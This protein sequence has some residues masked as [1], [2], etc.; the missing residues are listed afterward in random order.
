LGFEEVAVP[1]AQ[2]E[3]YN[4]FIVAAEVEFEFIVNDASGT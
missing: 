1:K 2:N 3:A 4:L